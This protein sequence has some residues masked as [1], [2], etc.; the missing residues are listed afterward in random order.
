MKTKLLFACLLSLGACKPEIQV[1]VEQVRE[2]DNTPQWEIQIDRPEFSSADAKTDQDCRIFNQKIKSFIQVFQDSLKN[3]ACRYA[4]EMDAL[5]EQPIGPFQLYVQDSVF[6]A[7][8]D[9]W[10]VRL[11]VYTLEGGANG[12]TNFYAFNYQVKEQV[13]LNDRDLLSSFNT[14]EINALLQ[15]NLH[16]P[17]NCFDTPP[18][19]DNYSCLNVN[20]EN[21][22]FTYDPYI[23]GPH[24]CGYATISI[25]KNKLK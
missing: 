5:G 25:P 8:A 21:L 10:S 17:E 19:L 18:T 23:L 22:I 12:M 24:S 7:G 14:T 13:F 3:Q 2:T 15:T 4:A 6:S 20:Q 1:S 16:N 9:L 11:S